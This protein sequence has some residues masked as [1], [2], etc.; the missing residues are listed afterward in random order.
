MVITDLA[1][2]FGNALWR[3]RITRGQVCE[4][5]DIAPSNLS[6][7]VNR[8]FPTPYLVEIMDSLGYD[9]EFRWVMKQESADERAE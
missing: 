1:F 3:K 4:I 7:M 2:S 9:L 5:F 8:D 6:R